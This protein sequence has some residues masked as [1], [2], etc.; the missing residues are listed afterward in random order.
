TLEGSMA[1]RRVIA[2]AVL[3]LAAWPAGASDG[4]TTVYGAGQDS[5]AD[6]LAAHATGREAPMEIALRKIDEVNWVAGFFTGAEAAYGR[7][8]GIVGGTSS[9]DLMA[10]VMAQCRE[11]P[12]DNLF[13]ASARTVLKILKASDG[14]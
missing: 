4:R 12:H 2:A 14:Q 8:I 1:G 9:G 5:C 7:P 6:A 13:Q 3:L 10:A 11:S